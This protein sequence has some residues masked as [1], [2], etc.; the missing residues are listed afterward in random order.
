VHAWPFGARA[1]HTPALHHAFTLHP[2]SEAHDVVHALPTQ[3]NGAHASGAQTPS[4]CPVVA[5][6]QAKHDCV[7]V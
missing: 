6:E 5:C 7:H 2:V 4:F 3:M 1:A